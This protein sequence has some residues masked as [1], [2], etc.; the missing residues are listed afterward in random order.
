MKLERV[1]WTFLFFLR[2]LYNNA[3]LYVIWLWPPAEHYTTAQFQHFYS[4]DT[5]VIINT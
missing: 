2:I 3:S 5:V 1:M 4:I